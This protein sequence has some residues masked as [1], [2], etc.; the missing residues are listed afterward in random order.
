MCIPTILAMTVFLWNHLFSA[1]A[2]INEAFRDV[3]QAILVASNCNQ[4]VWYQT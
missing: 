4:I 1:L 3:F 2:K